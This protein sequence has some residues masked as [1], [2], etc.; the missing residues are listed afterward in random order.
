[1]A[2]QIFTLICLF[3]ATKS[4]QILNPHKFLVV[5]HALDL[6]K[7]YLRIEAMKSTS[8]VSGRSMESKY[9]ID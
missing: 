5:T 7:S 8:V 9:L 3:N 2:K 6:I 1:M 4:K